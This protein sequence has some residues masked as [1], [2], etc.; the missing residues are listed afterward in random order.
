MPSL[1]SYCMPSDDGAAP[2]PYWR[3]CTLVICKPGIRA[4][5]NKGDWI[6]GTGAKRAFLGDGTTRD[7]SGRLIYAMKVTEKMTMPEYDVHTQAKL[8]GKVPDWG[9]R[10]VRRRVGDSLYDFSKSRA[11]P[12]QRDGVHGAGN[13]KTDLRGKHAL[14]STHFYYFGDQ[15]IRLPTRLREIAQN[16]RGHRRHVNDRYLEEFVRW[17]DGLGLRPGVLVGQPLCDLF[18]DETTSVRCAKER[19]RTT[20]RTRK[21]AVPTVERSG[22]PRGRGFTAYLL[23]DFAKSAARSRIR[24]SR[25]T[26]N[27]ECT[28]RGIGVDGRLSRPGRHA[29]GL[30]QD[31]Y[32]RTLAPTERREPRPASP[33]ARPSSRA[34]DPDRCRSAS[35]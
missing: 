21:S 31:V 12:K 16:R 28:S 10:D 11:A 14:L 6:A 13:V 27:A 4:T 23:P 20:R 3:V 33:L 25:T 29:H 2:N 1:Y 5:A 35:R 22:R 8:A 19:E 9:H 34:P 17:I 32:R 18:E 26:T 15:A 7:M 30:G 24:G